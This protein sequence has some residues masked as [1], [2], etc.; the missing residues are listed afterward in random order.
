MKEKQMKKAPI[1]LEPEVPLFGRVKV[2]EELRT[3][4]LKF[5][6]WMLGSEPPVTFP[7][8]P[9]QLKYEFITPLGKMVLVNNKNQIRD[10]TGKTITIEG[11]CCY[12]AHLNILVLLCREG[13]EQAA[14]ALLSPESPEELKKFLA[15]AIM[16]KESVTEDMIYLATKIVQDMHYQKRPGSFSSHVEPVLER[17]CLSSGQRKL[18]CLACGT[19]SCDKIKFLPKRAYL[20]CL[21]RGVMPEEKTIALKTYNLCCLGKKKAQYRLST[22]AFMVILEREKANLEKKT[23]IAMSKVLKTKHFAHQMKV[24]NVQYRCY[25]V[26][27]RYRTDNSSHIVL[28]LIPKSLNS[29]DLKFAD[30]NHPS[31]LQSV[32]GKEGSA[33][34]KKGVV[35]SLI[36]IRD[37]SV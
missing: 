24:A 19:W 28:L 32:E 13:L 1:N 34:N 7:R 29:K 33:T 16:N 9:F 23:T 26:L 11:Y 2:K 15:L 6:P 20:E 21:K 8:A 14:K 27:F 36:F 37:T 35:D 18:F 10:E 25:A 22:E 31:K 4:K 3:L 30:C 12:A 5:V 17:L